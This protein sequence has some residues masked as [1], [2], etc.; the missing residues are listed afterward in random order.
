MQ[1]NFMALGNRL[2][3]AESEVADIEELDPDFLSE[4]P[5]E[6]RS[7]V[8]ND[9][10]RRKLAHRSGLDLNLQ[11]PGR[12][13]QASRSRPA[14]SGG[15]TKIA[16]PRPPAKVSFTATS[17]SS[18][19]EVKDMLSAWHRETRDEGP[20]GADVEVF[21]RYLARIITEERD[22][23]KARKFVKWLDWLVGTGEDGKGK[24]GWGDALTGVK[25]AVQRALE[26]R[27]LGPMSF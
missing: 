25:T 6:V 21:E 10:R 26:D 3:A 7:E 11:A 5:E 2:A 27:G 18:V 14:T 1:T 4:L 17:L 24:E 13:G 20:H 23:E 9:H 16:F 15:Q 22:M 19:Q 8:I 12:R